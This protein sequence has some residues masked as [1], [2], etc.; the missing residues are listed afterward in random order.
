MKKIFSELFSL[1]LVYT[2]VFRQH[3]D[4]FECFQDIEFIDRFQLYRNLMQSVHKYM[5]TY[6]LIRHE[7]MIY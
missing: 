3:L 4:Y 1:A 5:N 6:Y 2:K 7:C